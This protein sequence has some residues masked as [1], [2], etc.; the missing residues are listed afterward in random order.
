MLDVLEGPAVEPVSLAEV[1]AFLRLEHDEEDGLLSALIRAARQFCESSVRRRLIRQRLRLVSDDLYPVH[2]L[3]A[4]PVQRVEQVVLMDAQ[5]RADVLPEA[6]YV[7]SGDRL[8]SLTRWPEPRRP[9]G[10]FRVDYQ[11]GYGETPE[12]V[13]EPL[14]QGIRMLVAHWYENRE[15]VQDIG[16]SAMMPLGVAAL[17]AAFRP[18]RL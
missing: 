14:R 1:K 12:D 5:G 16:Q 17:W 11:V 2:R 15:A 7:V 8:A 18:V 10:G 3:P 4:G 9:V 13:P 6:A